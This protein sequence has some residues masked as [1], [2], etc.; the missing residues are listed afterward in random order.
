MASVINCKE[1]CY[2][3]C[4]ESKTNIV[5]ANHNKERYHLQL[6]AGVVQSGQ[7]SSPTAVENTREK[8]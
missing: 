5:T 8:N 3:K 2:S 6:G 7:L 1:Q 4:D